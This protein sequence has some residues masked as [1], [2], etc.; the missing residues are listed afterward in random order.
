MPGDLEATLAVLFAYRNKMLHLG[1]EWPSRELERFEEQL[2]SS[3]WPTDWFSK[4]TS[5][6]RP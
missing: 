2:E 4:A 6:D 5:D 3:R 1:F